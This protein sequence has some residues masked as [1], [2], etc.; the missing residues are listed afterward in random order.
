[1]KTIALCF[2]ARYPVFFSTARYF[3]T[4]FLFLISSHQAFSQYLVTVAGTGNGVDWNSGDNGPAIQAQIGSL[5]SICV[6]RKGNFYITCDHTI[7]KVDATTG[8]ITKFAGN[9]YFA[10]CGDGGSAI[11]AGI[12]SPGGV[13]A[14]KAGNIYIAETGANRI[15]KVDASGIITTFAGTGMR[16]YS[17]DGSLAINAR[18]NSPGDIAVDDSGNVFFADIDNY[19]IRKIAAGT[20]IITTIAGIGIESYSGDDGPAVNAGILSPVFICLDKHG[21]IFFTEQPVGVSHRIRKISTGTGIITTVA[22]KGTSWGYSGDGGLVSEARFDCLNGIAVDSSDNIYVGEFWQSRIRRIDASTGIVTSI[23][24]TGVRDF[25]G[26]GIATCHALHCPRDLAFDG[27]NNLYVVDNAN[28]R[29]R[30]ITTSSTTSSQV[31]QIRASQTEICAG[32]PVHFTATLN[33]QANIRSYQ[34]QVNGNTSGNN[35]SFSSDDL[36]E[37]DKINCII[38]LKD[39][40]T[41]SITSN[42][43]L[44]KVHPSP[45]VSFVPSKIVVSPGDQAQLNPIV[46]GDIIAHQ[47][48]PSNQLADPSSIA[49][50]TIALTNTT[51]YELFVS[52]AHGCEDTAS[53][54]AAVY[55]KLYMPSAFTPNGDGNNDLFRIPPNSTIDLKEFSIFDRWG[56]MVFSTTDISRGWNGKINGVVSTTGTFVYIIKGKDI[57]GDVFVKGVV[58]LI[59]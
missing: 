19:R 30:K 32:T 8:I 52:N 34:W 51:K 24:G 48:T 58:T 31:V 53:I 4:L 12:N 46:Q 18:L 3:L 40:C 13:C 35:A 22:G 39:N 14:D 26:D 9:G 41:N 5:I 23:A 50:H 55:R 45:T 36:K 15:R 16:G 44:M 7:R 28:R 57:K 56:K 11:A 47:W 21:N 29:I 2:R 10:T 59:R 6:D 27:A 49:P 42:D 33:V 37:G 43:I 20:Q 38:T 1:V 17:G 54:V 25:D